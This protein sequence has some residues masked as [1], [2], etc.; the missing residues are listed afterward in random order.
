MA[1]CNRVHYSKQI[2]RPYAKDVARVKAARRGTS[3]SRRHGDLN[4][5]NPKL[6]LGIVLAIGIIFAFAVC[7]SPD[8]LS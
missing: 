3:A 6:W 1:L 2:G 4:E 7:T 8:S 5:T